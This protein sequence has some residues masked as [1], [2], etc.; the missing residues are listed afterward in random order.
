MDYHTGYYGITLS[1]KT[2][3]A[4]HIARECD[5]AR[6][7]IVVF[8]PLN[9]ATHGGDWPERSQLYSDPEHFAK[10]I[11]KMENAQVFV[12]EADLVFGHSQKHNHWLMRRGRHQGL[13]VH[14]I[15][16]RPNLVDPSC[17]SMCARAY[18]FRL[19]KTDRVSILADHGHDDISP[20]TGHGDFIMVDNR[21]PEVYSGNVF[22][23]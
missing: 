5:K 18:I 22:K 23:L 17:R 11:A 3:M 13:Y 4:R 21:S 10:A 12:D 14:L 20:S 16:Q 19:N 8:D 9:T 15:T 6:H 2:T 1:G 7:A